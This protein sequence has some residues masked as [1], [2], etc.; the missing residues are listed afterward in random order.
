MWDDVVD[1]FASDGVTTPAAGRIRALGVR[2]ALERMGPAGLTTGV[3]NDRL[4]FDTVVTIAPGGRERLPEAS[5]GMLRE[6]GSKE[7]YW[8][9][10]LPQ[11]VREGERH[12]EGARDARL[13]DP[14]V[15]LC[16]WLGRAVSTP[17]TTG[18]SG[19]PREHSRQAQADGPA[20]RH[21]VRRVTADRRGPRGRG[22][23][24]RPVAARRRTT[25]AAGGGEGPTAPRR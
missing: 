25:R 17:P 14:P 13:S 2:A 21:A 1:L 19:V 10:R 11:P 7:A 6:S 16:R 18:R 5:T 22:V 4:Q 23:C 8:R 3:L 12:L 24:H 20:A 15:R 9:E